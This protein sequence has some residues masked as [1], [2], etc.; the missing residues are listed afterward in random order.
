L[1]AGYAVRRHDNDDVTDGARQHTVVAHCTANLDPHLFLDA[2]WP[3]FDR[4]D[5]SALP[6]IHH[7]R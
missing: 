5:E 1:R 3:N 6:D 2:V 4:T 7:A